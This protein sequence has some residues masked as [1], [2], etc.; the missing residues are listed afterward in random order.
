MDADKM[1]Q[2]GQDLQDEYKSSEAFK[3]RQGGTQGQEKETM[4]QAIN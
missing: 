2:D 3:L 4:K 1:K